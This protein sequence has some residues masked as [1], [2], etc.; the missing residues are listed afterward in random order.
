MGLT[1]P[2]RTLPGSGREP[3][4]TKWNRTK[5][6]CTRSNQRQ[7]GQTSFIWSKRLKPD[8]TRSNQVVWAGRAAAAG[9]AKSWIRSW[10]RG[11][12]SQRIK[13]APHAAAV[14][15]S[16]QLK[17]KKNSSTRQQ[18]M[19]VT[20]VTVP[21]RS[22]NISSSKKQKKSNYFKQWISVFFFSPPFF[23]FFSLPLNYFLVSLRFLFHYFALQPTC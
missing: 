7:P 10:T 5:P 14:S 1:L 21:L 19:F 11:S 22:E 13:P 2:P 12:G 16:R 4:P 9:S 6:G 8:R 18:L 20:S 17:H 15:G 23:L 3:D